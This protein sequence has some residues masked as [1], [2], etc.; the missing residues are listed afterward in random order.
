MERL[1]E[2]HTFVSGGAVA[3][4]MNGHPFLA[5]NRRKNSAC[6]ITPAKAKLIE[7]HSN[8]CPSHP[9]RRMAKAEKSNMSMTNER[10]RTSPV[11]T[12]VP[13]IGVL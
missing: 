5:R 13:H 9:A 8:S 11:P 1:Q 10:A 12:R 4:A 6:A 3:E 2:A 7:N